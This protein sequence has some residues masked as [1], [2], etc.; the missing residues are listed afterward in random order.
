MDAMQPVST[1]VSASNS[2]DIEAQ[3]VQTFGRL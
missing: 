1:A 2:K 3:A